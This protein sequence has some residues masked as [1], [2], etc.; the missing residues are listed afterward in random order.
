MVELVATSAFDAAL[1]IE[2]GAMTLSEVDLGPV[3]FVQ[4]LKG[5]AEAVSA[6]L[7]SSLG[8]GLPGPGQALVG[9]AARAL[10][11]GPGQALVMGDCPDLPGAATVD[12]SDAFSTLRIEGAAARDVLARLTP[13]DVRAGVFEQGQTARSLIGHMTGQITPLASDAF[14]LMVFRS[15]AGTLFH[16]VSRAAGFVAGRV[17][18]G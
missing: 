11:C 12:Q 9:D 14:E 7:K 13:L 6:A 4:P 8:V 17:A 1:P 2:L 3:M 15:M 5:Q 18:L 10:W 16:E